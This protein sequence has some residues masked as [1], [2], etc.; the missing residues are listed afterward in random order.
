[1]LSRRSLH[2]GLLAVIA[3]GLLLLL[4][5]RTLPPLNLELRS[6]WEKRNAFTSR[7]P[8]SRNL[9]I[10]DQNPI[11][12]KDVLNKTT[13]NKLQALYHRYIMSSQVLCNRV[14]RMGNLHDGGW[15]LCEDPLY[16]PTKENCLVYSY[17]I[18]FDFSFDDAMEKYGCE[19]HSFDPSMNERKVDHVRGQ[20][21]HF[22][23]VGV[24]GVD[25]TIVEN[26]GTWH[27]YTIA[28]HRRRLHHKLSERRLD[29]LKIDVEGYELEALMTALDDGSLDDVR[30]LIFETHLTMM[31]G[32][33]KKK[34]YVQYLTL[35]RKIYARGFRI[36][37][38]HRNM[39][40]VFHNTLDDKDY[41]KCHEVHTVKVSK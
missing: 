33:P 29:V 11:P 32:S 41:V 36:H 30:Q 24:A 31:G 39:F 12:E 17:G 10:P 2:L 16:A 37:T 28:S 26:S 15:E 25:K 6:T 21:V 27:L 18:N 19:V 9:T 4:T 40:S 5:W 8:N 3:A 23:P 22:H 34:N 13:L 35:L 38:T 1:M 14:T 7:S 20:R